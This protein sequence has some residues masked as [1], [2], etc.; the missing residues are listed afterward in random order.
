MHVSMG[1]TSILCLCFFAFLTL[2]M[3]RRPIFF[4]YHTDTNIL[5]GELRL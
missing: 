5:T 3:K 1:P 2:L 4:A